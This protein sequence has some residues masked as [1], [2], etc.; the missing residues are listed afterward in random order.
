MTREELIERAVEF[1]EALMEKYLMEEELTDEEIEEALKKAGETF[2]YADINP[3]NAETQFYKECKSMGI[4]SLDKA[5]NFERAKLIAANYGIHPE[6]VRDAFMNALEKESTEKFAEKKAAKYKQEVAEQQKLKITPKCGRE[7][8]LEELQSQQN[9]LKRE[10]KEIEEATSSLFSLGAAAM[11]S[12]P[13]SSG[14]HW[15]TLGGIA[16]GIAGPAAGVAVALEAQ[17]QQQR[18]AVRAEAA[19][20]DIA[21]ATV[22]AWDSGVQKTSRIGK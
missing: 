2:E 4:D 8:I 14:P 10:C 17:A 22:K 9:K 6:S 7:R 18:E 13:T 12:I 19:K 21:D 1:D 15:A 3:T 5:S 20:Q 16:N 11:A